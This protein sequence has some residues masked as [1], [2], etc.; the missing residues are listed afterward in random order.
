MRD[1]QHRFL[2]LLGKLPARLTVEQA[3]WVINCQ[4]HDIPVLVNARLL[5][6]LGNPP[7]NG[8]KFFCTEDVLEVAKDRNWLTKMSAAI[9]QHWQRQNANKRKNRTLAISTS[10]QSTAAASEVAA[11]A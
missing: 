5:K 4:P 9:Y 8:V 6:P 7:A 2:I 10:P 11:A 1:E 3:A